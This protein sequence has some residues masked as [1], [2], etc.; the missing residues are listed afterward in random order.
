MTLTV[1]QQ[2]DFISPAF[3]PLNFTLSSTVSGNA[4]MYYE[5]KVFDSGSNLISTFRHLPRPSGRLW[6]DAHRVVEPFLTF[7]IEGLKVK[8]SGFK[9]ANVFKYYRCDFT[10]WSAS[11]STVVSGSTTSVIRLGINAALTERDFYAT[12]FDNWIMDESQG[13]GQFLTDRTRIKIRDTESYELGIMTAVGIGVSDADHARIRFFDGTDTEI[14][15]TTIS[16][17]IQGDSP[18]SRRFLKFLCGANDLTV[19]S[20]TTYY[21]VVIEDS[22]NKV[23]CD[24]ITFEIYC[25]KIR[26]EL[27]RLYYL[28]HY[29]RI[30]AL[31][32]YSP[33]QFNHSNEKREFNKIKGED[34]SGGY[35][36]D[37]SQHS[38]VQY[39]TRI[40]ENISLKTG[41]INDEEMRAVIELLNSPAIWWEIDDEV[42]I[43]VNMVTSNAEKK[44][45]ARNKLFD[46]D[47]EIKISERNFTQRL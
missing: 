38:V 23:L 7:D 20:G 27:V 25:P 2:P 1:I 24:A 14:S 4:G 28:N 13:T 11:G 22:A 35:T 40:N 34:T 44:Y 39:N 33:A 12:V 5:T 29:G 21:T 26:G 36:Y 16:N 45:R 37:S 42:L 46:A 31:T 43:P 17:T 32:F 9:E 47:I 19:P 8:S 6:F 41:W 18:V 10:E 30:D 3:N 15:N